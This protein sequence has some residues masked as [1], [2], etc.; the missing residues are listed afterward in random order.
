MALSVRARLTLWYAIVVIV[1]LAVSSAAMLTLQTRLALRRLDAEL[2]RLSATV[3][4]ILGNEIDE[5]HE[6][7]AAAADA[8]AEAGIEGRTVIILDSSGRVL[9][10]SEKGP[11][12][13]LLVSP[14]APGL[15]S[16]V[17]NVRMIAVNGAQAGLAY[18]IRI[19]ASLDVMADE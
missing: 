12:P 18:E 9:A 1:I 7:V 4:T 11:S 8:I 2:E 5:R 14:G 15:T 16:P 6:M 10:T 19:A 17:D 3:L 13:A